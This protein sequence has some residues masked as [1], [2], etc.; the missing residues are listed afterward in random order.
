MIDIY[1]FCVQSEL[2]DDDL[3]PPAPRPAKIRAK[4]L[5]LTYA[6][7]E[8]DPGSIVIA[9]E[10]TAGIS[11]RKWIGVEEKH[12][13][14]EPHCHLLLHLHDKPNLDMDGL[15]IRGEGDSEYHPNVQTAG[16]KS[17]RAKQNKWWRAK[18]AY[19]HK[20]GG[21]YPAGNFDAWETDDWRDYLANKRDFM[22]WRAD[23]TIKDSVFPF[24]IPYWGDVVNAPQA[25]E[26]KNHWLLW[27]KPGFGK[28][29]WIEQTFA[30]KSVFRRNPDTKL[31]Y[32][33]Y[34]GEQ[35]II[36]DDI[37]PCREEVI[38]MGEYREIETRVW[39][40]TRYAPAYM[41]LRQRCVFIVCCNSLD[42]IPWTGDAAM[43]AR[44]HVREL[45]RVPVAPP[46]HDVIEIDM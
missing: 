21:K 33:G 13:S 39:G 30:G 8:L 12:R 44:F 45:K 22:A 20:V 6:N 46:M 32:E 29:P 7:C 40:G 17:D 4:K 9:L 43:K 16:K 38:W 2:S 36:C 15:D 23:R 10:E 25:G 37:V 5:F 3:A 28:T 18:I 14:G 24:V 41:K 19:V 26:K 42:S 1:L 31:A 35:L 11:V 27:S 34:A